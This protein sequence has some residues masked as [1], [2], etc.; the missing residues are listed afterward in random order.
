VPHLVRKRRAAVGAGV[1]RAEVPAGSRLEAKKQADE[2]PSTSLRDWA[3]RHRF[4]QPGT[5]QPFTN[6]V[7]AE[8]APGNEIVP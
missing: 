7:Y 3:L 2:P 6:Y 8:Q 5:H 1:G 4:T